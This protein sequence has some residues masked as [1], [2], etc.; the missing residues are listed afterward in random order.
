MK[1]A[2]SL[3]SALLPKNYTLLKTDNVP[4]K[5]ICEYFDLFLRRKEILC[6]SVILQKRTDQE[7][8]RSKLME[9]TLTIENE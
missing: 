7:A 6:L 1:F 2:V 4:G 5:K 8:E 3:R 9:D